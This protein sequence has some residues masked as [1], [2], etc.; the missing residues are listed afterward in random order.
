MKRKRKMKTVKGFAKI[1]L[2]LDVTEIMDDGYHSVQTVMQ[3]LSLCDEVTV[4]LRDETV[5][6]AECNVYGVPTDDKNIAVRA[7]KLY[8]ETISATGGVHIVI[9]KRI[10]MAAGLAGGSADAAATLVAL[11][12]IFNERLGEDALCE[13]GAKLGADVPFCISCGT[14]YSDGRGDKLHSFPTLD[15]SLIFV[16]ACG[17]E[18]VSTPWGYRLL[19]ETFDRFKNYAPKGTELLRSAIESED[20]YAF[21]KHAFN[22]FE[23][24]VLRDRPV[25]AQIKSIMQSK[26]AR[27]AMMSGSGP[28]VFGVF[29]NAEIAKEVTKA[30][31]ECGY[32]AEVATPVGERYTRCC[33]E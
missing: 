13:L 14:H 30:I 23:T 4:V 19:D 28:S 31:R 33:V 25:A 11:D 9:E 27:C 10:P 21:C 26:G 8:F 24:P 2:H 1:N 15:S 29:E 7:A 20:K 22:I 3:S 5:F 18:G 12:S 32:F 17:G 6:D 16:V